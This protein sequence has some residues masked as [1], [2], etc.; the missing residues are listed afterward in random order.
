[1]KLRIEKSIYGGAGLARIAAA[2]TA[3]ADTATQDPSAQAGKTVFVPMTLPGEL[4]E[5][6]ITEDHKTFADA[7][8]KAILEAATTRT[9]PPC[10]YYGQCGGCHYQHATYPQQLEMKTAILRETLERAGVFHKSTAPGIGILSAAHPNQS[11][12]YRNRIRLHVR[13][14][15][16]TSPPTLCYRERAS[17][18][19]LPVNDCPIAAPI[20][21]RALQCIQQLAASHHLDQLCNEVELFTN[22]QQDS[23]L[24]SLTT[25]NLSPLSAV[26][27][28]KQLNQLCAALQPHLPELK[29]AAIFTTT[30]T[31]APNRSNKSRTRNITAT[32]G[33]QH[34]T[35]PAA[36]FNYKV[37]LSSFFQTNR[38]L[39]D[40]L[41]NLITA[42][43]SGEIVWD[44]YAG[45]GLFSR[46]LTRTFRQV[47]AVES[48]PTA[49]A[50]LRHN[51]HGTTHKIVESTTL[52]FLRLQTQSLI[53]KSLIPDLVVVDPPRA[54]L[55]PEVTCLLARIAP[56]EI[57]Y[58]SCDPT[59][60]A[61]DLRALLQSG[62]RLQSITLVD[63][64]PQ[65]FHI[66]SVSRL[67]LR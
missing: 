43:R 37:S 13:P 53:K 67:S 35:Y 8:I 44:L 12:N 23:V 17:H 11:W 7:E 52:D 26:A 42:G 10:P 62:Y 65:T 30:D 39:V 51:L 61:R 55:G 58:V 20:L 36:T 33:E 25:S 28:S 41:V 49:C 4:V 22:P 16:P 63:L 45:V 18:A 32:W 15:S 59:T 60:V 21:I 24:I 38:H 2:D 57:V 46:A 27:L 40:P 1:M 34:L 31:P 14:A 9:Q 29:G 6:C 64:F 47:R 5:A 19:L 56:R 66:E 54:G 48:A 50:D 3:P